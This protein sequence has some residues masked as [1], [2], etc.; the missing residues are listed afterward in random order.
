MIDDSTS[1]QTLRT[2][3]YAKESH[4]EWKYRRCIILLK[5]GIRNT[6]YHGPQDARCMMSLMPCLLSSCNP[7]Y[8]MPPTPLLV[9]YLWTIGLWAKSSGLHGR[10]TPAVQSPRQMPAQLVM[11]RA[12]WDDHRGAWPAS[13]LALPRVESFEQSSRLPTFVPANPTQSERLG[14]QPDWSRV[15]NCSSTMLPLANVPGALW[16]HGQVTP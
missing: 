14:Q 8:S 13:V 3:N 12:A 2:S 9:T 10:V 7:Q 11:Q 5:H 4:Q 16:R 6:V 15:I 1:N